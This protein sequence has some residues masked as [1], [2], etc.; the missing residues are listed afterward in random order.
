[1]EYTPTTNSTGSI[2]GTIPALTLNNRE[3]YGKTYEMRIHHFLSF[4]FLYLNIT[5]PQEML[6]FFPHYLSHITNL[7]HKNIRS[8]KLILSILIQREVSKKSINQSSLLSSANTHELCNKG[9]AIV[10]PH[11][12]HHTIVG[13]RLLRLQ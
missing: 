12:L 8:S 7:F 11:S 10:L 6:L 1:M 3:N 2:H 4:Q 5:V 13:A 9:R